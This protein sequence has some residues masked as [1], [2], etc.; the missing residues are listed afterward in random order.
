MP[1]QNALDVNSDGVVDILDLV[2]FVSRFGQ[3]GQD[4]ADVNENGIVD[5]IDVLLVAAHMPTLSQQAVEMFTEADVQQWLTLAK[6]LEVENEL[7]KRGIV[8]LEHL[9]AVL[10]AVTVD[11]PDPN[12][13]AAVESTLGGTSGDPIGSLEM[14]TLTELNAIDASISDLTGP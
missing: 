13:R 2:P 3:R 10:T 6:Q 14:A 5:I 7:L 1:A 11:I 8:G 9:F 4:P 12:L